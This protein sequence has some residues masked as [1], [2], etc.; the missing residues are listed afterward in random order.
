[1]KKAF[2]ITILII[3]CSCKN[4]NDKNK[5]QI[6]PVKIQTINMFI[7]NSDNQ[8]H[9][10]LDTTAIK[11]DDIL[12]SNTNP[13]GLIY[14]LNSECSLCL[15]RFFEFLHILE[16]SKHTKLS[17]LAII[18]PGT[19]SEVDYYCQKYK[20]N[21]YSNIQFVEITDN[22]VVI[23]KLEKLNGMLYYFRNRQVVKY[24]QFE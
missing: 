7:S 5:Q 21:I 14:V 22:N 12:K 9:L 24:M 11:F 13:A 17:V 2:I 8:N 6:D 3:S 20:L 23:N 10:E 15:A 18:S 16:N 1:M 4:N 19:K